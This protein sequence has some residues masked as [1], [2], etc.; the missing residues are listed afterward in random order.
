MGLSL[1]CPQGGSQRKGR[2]PAP[3][4][5][6]GSM[7]RLKPSQVAAQQAS[8]QGLALPSRCLPTPRASLS[9]VAPSLCRRGL[10]VQRSSHNKHSNE[11]SSTDPDAA[12]QQRGLNDVCF[13]FDADILERICLTVPVGK[14]TLRSTAT[15]SC[16]PPAGYPEPQRA[17]T[18]L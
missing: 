4:P 15:P 18:H 13:S 3:R 12:D 2:P 7:E 9:R 8:A 5:D 10:W 14:E 1:C 6:K 11:G 17:L 16:Q